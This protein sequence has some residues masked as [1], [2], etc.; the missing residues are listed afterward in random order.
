MT[1][2]EYLYG[3]DVE[4]VPVPQEVIMR[5]VEQLNDHL[6][7]LLEVDYRKRDGVRC[8]AIMRAIAFW[9]K[10]DEEN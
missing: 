3:E 2:V 9:E 4:V 7:E 8:N 1:K 5:R 10:L 6:S